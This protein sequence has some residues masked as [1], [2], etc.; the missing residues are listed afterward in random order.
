MQVGPPK[1]L[2][3]DWR[4]DIKSASNIPGT[5]HEPVTLLKLRVRPLCLCWLR[6]PRNR[7]ARPCMRDDSPDVHVS[8][9]TR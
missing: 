8:E 2:D 7:D 9:P 5:K 6:H 4:V 1:Y 3:M